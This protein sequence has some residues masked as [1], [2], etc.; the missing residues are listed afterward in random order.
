MELIEL[1]FG[2]IGGR[3]KINE[4]S[5]GSFTR[6]FDLSDFPNF[7]GVKQSS[8]STNT[9]AGTFRGI[10]FQEGESAENKVLVCLSGSVFDAVVNISQP[11][12]FTFFELGP[13][14]DMQV[15]YIPKEFAH[16]FITLE[17][18]T[19]LIYFIDQ[20]YDSESSRGFRWNDPKIQ[21]PWP[22][23]PRVISERD[24]GFV[25]IK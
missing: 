11:D 20:F 7:N 2:L 9:L 4:D 15:L 5:R 3:I 24:S 22:I 10:H 6:L 18:N 16:G 17:P 21:I 14:K 8:F 1:G 25:D 13:E 19:N 12:N 23:T